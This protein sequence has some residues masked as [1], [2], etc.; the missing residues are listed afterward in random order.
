MKEAWITRLLEQHRENLAVLETQRAQHGIDP[1]LDLV[2][3]IKREKIEIQRLEELLASLEQ[4]PDT[5]LAR[6]ASSWFEYETVRLRGDLEDLRRSLA[7]WQAEAREEMIVA[8][9]DRLTP[10]DR[11]LESLIGKVDKMD[12]RLNDAMSTL[13]VHTK[14]NRQR[15]DALEDQ[16]SVLRVWVA[17]SILVGV[18]DLVLLVA[19]LVLLPTGG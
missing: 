5:P 10:V 4:V 17:A 16:L 1:P 6:A 15:I 12:D 14:L 2:N 3:G 8:I 18:I 9:D 19:L 13:T 11:R 7:R